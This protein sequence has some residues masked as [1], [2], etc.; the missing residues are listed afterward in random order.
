M[1]IKIEVHNENDS[2]VHTMFSR[3]LKIS[4][5]S[6]RFLISGRGAIGP[7]VQLRHPGDPIAQTRYIFNNLKAFLAEAGYMLNDVIRIE[8]AYTKAVTPE[9]WAALNE[10]FAEFV[11]DIEVKPTVGALRLIDALAESR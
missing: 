5:F 4:H 6:E 11:A 9:Q 1:A 3:G 8:G 7:D 2:T 10:V